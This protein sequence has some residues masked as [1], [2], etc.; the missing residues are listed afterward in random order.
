MN[1]MQ[2]IPP[3]LKPFIA[4]AKQIYSEAGT[5]EISFS[6]PTYQ[7]RVI[8]PKTKQEFWTFLQLDSNDEAQDCFCSC[9]DSEQGGC[10]HLAFSILALFDK[11][12]LPLHKRFS[13]SFWNAIGHVWMERYGNEEP[14]EGWEGTSFTPEGEKHFQLLG[15]KSLLETEENSL[16]FSN[17]S[18]EE[19]Q[20]WREG[21]P[22]LELVFELCFW[23]D[24]VKQL[25]I[26][27]ERHL[28][29]VEFRGKGGALPDELAI[30]SSDFEIIY[31][32]EKRDWK[33]LIPALNSVKSNLKTHNLLQD[34]CTAISYDPQ[35]GAFQF[36]LKK[37]QEKG[38][39][40]IEG[41]R[42]ISQEGFFPTDFPY[43][44]EL[45]GKSV[46]LFLDQYFF[47]IGP[48]MKGVKWTLEPAEVK[49]H[50]EFD[51]MWGLLIDPYIEKPQDLQDP[52]TRLWGPF[53]YLPALGFCRIKKDEIPDLPSLV[54]ENDLPDFIRKYSYWL[55]RYEGFEVHLG[56]LEA[57]SSY[58]IDKQG[59]LSFQRNFP[60]G[61]RKGKEFGPWIYVKGEGFY[62][63]SSASA[64]LP[65]DLNT[66][67]R[68]DLVAGFIRSNKKELELIPK[69]FSDM[70]PFKEVF[71]EV[72]FDE[73]ERI[74]VEPHYVLAPKF[75]DAE[76]RFYEDW[77]YMEGVGFC[78]IPAD[79]RLPDKAKE[80]FWVSSKDAAPFMEKELP[81]LRHW[82]QKIDP[83]LVPPN[84]QQLILDSLEEGPFHS[85][86]LQ[87][88][89]QT[90]RGAI[91]FQ[92][93][94]DAVKKKKPFVFSKNGLLDLSQNRFLWLKR[95]RPEAV[96]L[97]EEGIRLQFSTIELLRL[98]AFEELV[99]RGDALELFNEVIELKK[100]PPFDCRELQASLRPYQ[101][102]GA[103]W[104]FTLYS[105]LL[106]GLLCDE[107]GL[108][109]THQSMGLMASVRSL[110]P[111]AKFLVVC[112]TSVLYHWEDRLK[113]FFPSL[114]I[115]TFHGPFR[116]VPEE[117]DFS[118]L[119][120]S[121]G[122]VRTETEWLSS[123]RFDVA[124]YDEIQ[125]AKNHRSKLYGALQQVQADVKIGLTGTPIENRLR[126]LKALFD[127][128]L[129]GYMP[130]EG[131]YAHL[132]VKPIEKQGSLKQKGFLQR[133]IRP[134]VLRR[135]KQEVLT[136]LPSKTEEIARCD[137]AP[138]QERL[139]REVLLLH[140]DE[141]VSEIFN[142]KKGI[143]YLH[144]FALLARLKQICDHPA[145]YFK[146]PEE[147]HKHHSGKWDL[148]VELLEEARESGQKVVVYSQYLGMLDIIET[149][150][151]EHG[152]GFASLRG[153]TVDRKG[154]I[155]RFAKDP[156]CEVFVASLK[157]AGLGIDLTA[158][159][160]VIHY[161]RWWNA[162]RENQATDR[163]HRYGQS[164]G[165]Q[166]F[167]L[168]TKN[169]FEERIHQIIERKRELMEA[170]IGVDDHEVLKA[171][172][173]EELFQLL[174][175][176]EI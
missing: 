57:Q 132:I 13:A 124:V 9:Q 72:T 175:I 131:D 164:R 32:M 83:E 88:H 38:G 96:Q 19:I 118:L 93:V 133:L 151:Q 154:Q 99:A 153:S 163:V 139:Y 2:H 43:S 27:S 60:S 40:L 166:V 16:K 107:M 11:H 142:D 8:D 28:L 41:W 159:S 35:L 144:V 62:Q 147:Y 91:P 87:I 102:I 68:A 31:S 101:D 122:I 54:L 21:H 14:Q 26:Y 176:G 75:K 157:A 29:E 148:F 80:P 12:K 58:R 136:D 59:A 127:L 167:K 1:D 120:T 169:T 64:P 52:Q 85:W 109:K 86:I 160:V 171:F 135:R 25:M 63:R 18:G 149:Y 97:M 126:E 92:V 66:L 112:P 114:K 104:L 173:R 150:L 70:A 30:K 42:Y 79:Q 36:T 33:G 111:H 61:P 74:L 174:Q 82:V 117:G 69:F 125:V 162:A 24:F 134:F 39:I 22:S 137:L 50:L 45:S 121:Y 71:L 77:V 23:S 34:F 6:G 15:M 89:Y 90:D 37:H 65:L 129:P 48:L 158:A 106:G 4:K 152:I 108:G 119:L 155:S 113:E 51:E 84:V 115:L 110:R 49:Y 95:L 100:S 145:L 81:G 116:K 170:S 53:S 141:L 161:D 67:L 98:H 105:Y 73:K 10:W 20:A 168:V 46:E 146:K 55:N 156:S 140:R 165:V 17:L 130:S 138:S 172:T 47:E 76:Y 3:H 78:E 7:V 44:Q 56:S 143:P 94:Y 5:T 123:H 103:K 128:V